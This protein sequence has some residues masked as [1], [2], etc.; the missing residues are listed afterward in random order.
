MGNY[1]Q[2]AVWQRAHALTIEIYRITAVFPPEERFGLSAQLRRA[3]VSIESNI[4]EG[5]GG[6]GDVELRRYLR[7]A[8]GSARETECQ[9][10]IARDISLL[11]TAVWASLDRE[12]QEVTRMLSRLIRS[13]TSP[14]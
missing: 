1:K 14:R 4:A 7:I 5:N 2:L 10:M 8:R 3:A 13:L 11:N 12:I 6:K 9:L